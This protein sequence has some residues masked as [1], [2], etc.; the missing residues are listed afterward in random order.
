VKKAV[1]LSLGDN[2]EGFRIVG[3][4]QAYITHYKATFAQGSFW[5]KPLEAVIGAEV[6]QK[7]RLKLGDTFESS[8]GLAKSDDHH[9]TEQKFV[10]VGILSPTQSVIDRLILT[11][12]ESIWAVHSS[13]EK[14][15]SAHN[16]ENEQ[17]S[18]KNIKNTEDKQIT[19]WLILEYANNFA[20]LQLPREVQ[21]EGN[22]QSA[23]PA[24]EIHQVLEFFGFGSAFLQ[25]LGSVFVGLAG[26]SVGL[27][28]LNSFRERIYDLAILRAMGA[29]AWYIAGQ[30]V[31]EGLVLGV[32]GVF[33]G[34]LLGHL[35]IFLL[36]NVGFEHLKISAWVFIWA[37][38]YVF[39]GTLLLAFVASLFPAWQAYRIEIFKVINER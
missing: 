14:E 8:H 16:T 36:Q 24:L 38:L 1:P 10:V 20:A 37:E 23:Q 39:V 4:T 17:D 15:N 18:T 33:F 26:L 29:S 19:A 2:Y 28:L 27:A 12:L 35:G 6:A 34:L 30:V 32:L 9:H 5:K 3:T 21:K 31:V 13:K 11:S 25:I 7:L 22:L